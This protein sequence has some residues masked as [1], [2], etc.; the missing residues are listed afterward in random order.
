MNIARFSSLRWRLTLGYALVFA[1]T[2]LLGSL[3]VYLLTGSALNNTLDAA[4][5]DTATVALGNIDDPPAPPK[6]TA[7]LQPSPDL[8]VELLDAQGNRLDVV[9]LTDNERPPLLEGFNA[10]KSRRWYT[11]SADQHLLRVSRSNV[12]LNRLLETLARVLA[13]GAALMIAV[14]CAFGYLLADRAL[15]PVDAVASTAARIAAQIASRGSLSERVPQAPGGDEMARLTSTVNNMLERLEQ[16]VER[17]RG[18]ARAAAHEL[19]TPLTTIKGRLELA[20]ERPREALEYKRH[21]EAMRTRVDDL[22]ALIEQLDALARSDA[23][24]KLESV[25]LEAVVFEV[26]QGVRDSFEH[27]GKNLELDLQPA[28]VLAEVA[29]VRQVISNL[30]ENARKYGGQTVRVQTS[31]NWL[32]VS[33]N[34]SGPTHES[35]PRLLQSFE[36]GIGIQSISGSGLGLPLVAALGQRWGATLEPIWNEHGFAVRLTWPS[37][38]ISPPRAS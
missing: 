26:A 5:R 10:T 29:G 6:F 33:D 28:V 35:W 21:L 31:K 14:A 16:T 38:N 1:L 12:T 22:T 11:V 2:V 19:R 3:G 9:G 13:I 30:L 23:P 27:S 24:L 25:S 7:D 18:F 4:L 34:G 36:R 15:H 32:E 17:E 8:A 37:Q 20:L